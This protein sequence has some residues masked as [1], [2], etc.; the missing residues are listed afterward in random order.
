MSSPC[1][2]V[3]PIVL[4]GGAGR[5]LW[6]L[7]RSARPKPFLALNGARTL[8]Q[9]TVA[10]VRGPGFAPPLVVASRVHGALAAAQL[11]GGQGFDG[12]LLLEPVGRGTAPAVCLAALTVAAVRPEALLLVL[13]S[14]HVVEDD[15]ALRRAVA[16]ATP[17]AAA[18]ALVALGVVPTRPETGYGYIRPGAALAGA[19]GCA[20]IDRFVEKPDAATARRLLA[21]PGTLWNSGI[22]L[23]RADG[24]LAEAAGLCPEISAAMRRAH[25]AWAAGSVDDA[26]LA[27]AYAACPT[28]SL[29]R[30]VMERTARAA[31]VPVA[32]GWHDIG[33]W[34]A[35]LAHR[36]R[37]W[38]SATAG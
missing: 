28:A 8:L 21:E 23:F 35:L 24:F 7:S 4:C 38:R 10:R 25:A 3:H 15:A 34:P 1:P 26:A 9:E 31:V 16:T 32:M 13:P 20:A 11:G 6:P 12:T 22:F 37:R 19:P 33:T 27:E 30:A 18:G 29:D 14:D 17:A 36:F 5:R 2:P